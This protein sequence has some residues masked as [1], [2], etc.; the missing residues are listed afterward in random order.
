MEVN[1]TFLHI[2]CHVKKRNKCVKISAHE[3]L[4]YLWRIFK[5]TIL[6]SGRFFTLRLMSLILCYRQKFICMLESV[7]GWQ[8]LSVS[9]K[10]FT[11]YI[12]SILPI[13]LMPRKQLTYITIRKNTSHPTYPSKALLFLGFSSRHLCVTHP[14]RV[15]WK[16]T[17]RTCCNKQQ[18]MLLGGV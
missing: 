11:W 2:H 7:G 4:I 16:L 13:N 15:L 14:L 10:I 3:K 1:Q 9:N 18:N 12:W 17:S 6:E 8:S 5:R